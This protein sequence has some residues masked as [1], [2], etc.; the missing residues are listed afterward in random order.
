MGLGF[1]TILCVGLFALSYI[2]FKTYLLPNKITLPLIPIGILQFWIL[3]QNW[4]SAC[5]GAVVAYLGFVAVEKGFKAVRG[6]DGLG[7]GDAK[8]LAVGGAWC[9][10]SALPYI[11]LIASLT[12]ILFA[13]FFMRSKNKSQ[14]MI[15][16]GPFLALAIFL[17]WLCVYFEIIMVL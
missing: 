12:G 16:F 13:V 7:R 10:W 2:D 17:V 15:A 14:L 4:V 3:Q 9:G 5:I 6:K 1:G 11:I 8:L